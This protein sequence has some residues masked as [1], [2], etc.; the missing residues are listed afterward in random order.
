[1]WTLLA[2]GEFPDFLKSHPTF[3]SSTFPK[4]HCTINKNQTCDTTDWVS[5]PSMK[6]NF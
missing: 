4:T 1:M 3:V 6:N 5:L 2:V